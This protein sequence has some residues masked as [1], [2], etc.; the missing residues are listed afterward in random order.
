MWAFIWALLDFSSS[1]RLSRSRRAL[2][3]IKSRLQKRFQGD[4]HAVCPGLLDLTNNA[5]NIG[6]YALSLAL[7][8]W[9]S[10]GVG[11]QVRRWYSRTVIPCV[12]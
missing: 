1:D 9:P 7:M 3:D 2:V 8:N 10:C 5:E 4:L 12:I 6:F 11:T